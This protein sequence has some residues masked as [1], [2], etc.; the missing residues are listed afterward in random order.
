MKSSTLPLHGVNSDVLRDS[1]ST[2]GWHFKRI[3]PISAG[4]PYSAG[5]VLSTVVKYELLQDPE[6]DNGLPS[7]SVRVASSYLIAWDRSVR[8]SKLSVV[9][10]MGQDLHR[11][12]LST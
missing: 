10:Q 1:R 3:A 7:G 4:V 8:R 11:E 2:P 5:S 9:W 6:Q 12:R